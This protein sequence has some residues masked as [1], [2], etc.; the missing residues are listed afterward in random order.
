MN[1][2]ITHGKPM[3]ALRK[4]QSDGL[5]TKEILKSEKKYDRQVCSHGL[6]NM[7]EFLGK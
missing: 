5:F 1:K 3:E 2:K 6:E 7:T 4:R